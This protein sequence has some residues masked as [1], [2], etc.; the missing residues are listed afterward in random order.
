LLL[1]AFGLTATAAPHKLR[2]EDPVLVRQL[3]AQGAKVIGD[4]GTFS[5]LS[6]DDSLLGG[7][8]NRVEVA[9]EWNLIRL[10]ARPI[11]TSA[12]EAKALRKTVGAFTGKRLHLV[13][14][15]GPIKERWLAELK[16]SGVQVV[17]Y[18]PENAYLVYGDAAALARLQTWAGVSAFTQWEGEYGQ[19]LKVHPKARALMA[20]KADGTFESA[21]FA[22]QLIADTNSNTLALI[23]SLKTAPVLVDYQMDPYRNLVVSLPS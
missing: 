21:T 11:N 4:Y 13:Q 15:A 16:Q 18:I 7:I 2:I 5:V 10:N 6:A 22:I 19:D 17:S 8:S 12:P 1:C 23:N 20:R 3:V 14:F 9:D